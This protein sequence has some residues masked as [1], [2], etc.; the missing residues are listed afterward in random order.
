ME[1]DLEAA[2]IARHY[3]L[4]EGKRTVPAT[5]LLEWAEWYETTDRR[6]AVTNIGDVRVS[7]VFLGTDH[8]WGQG[9]PL[10]FE[11]MIFG[12]PLD[13]ECERYSTWEQ[14]EA[15]HK[16]MVE[17]ANVDAKIAALEAEN[18]RL[19]V[20]L[21]APIKAARSLLSNEDDADDTAEQW[22]DLAAAVRATELSIA[23][24][25]QPN[26]DGTDKENGRG[27]D[28]DCRT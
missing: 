2:S 15:G 23:E 27:R 13:E 12:G 22:N 20:Q 24:R 1:R 6:V 26:G 25:S 18:A 7:T 10:L 16:C 3:M 17:R 19:K 28:L 8:N 11:T 9:P 4:T 5:D 21:D 14:A